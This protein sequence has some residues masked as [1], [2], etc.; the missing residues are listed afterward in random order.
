M[1][2]EIDLQLI[3]EDKRS[4]CCS[5]G[6]SKDPA[7]ESPSQQYLERGIVINHSTELSE[8]EMERLVTL[9]EFL[10]TL[11]IIRRWVKF[12]SWETTFVFSLLSWSLVIKVG[13]GKIN[14][15]KWTCGE[16]GL[17][18]RIYL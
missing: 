6:K 17:N 2:I 3:A 14:R 5:D 15:V 7:F 13:N 12:K 16:E 4:V 11:Y 10:C 9:G 1:E 18:S 8:T